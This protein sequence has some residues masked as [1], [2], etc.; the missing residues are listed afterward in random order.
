MW[1]WKHMHSWPNW[2]ILLTCP[3]F[4]TF[5][6]PYPSLYLHTLHKQPSN[7]EN[8]GGFSL[9]Q[10]RRFVAVLRECFCGDVFYFLQFWFSSQM[11][12]GKGCWAWPWLSIQRWVSMWDLT[13]STEC[14]SI[15]SKTF[16]RL[17]GAPRLH[18]N[19][20]VL[21]KPAYETLKS[22]LKYNS[23]LSETEVAFLVLSSPQHS[24]KVEWKG[25]R[26]RKICVFLAACD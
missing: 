2:K 13:S 21:S 10:K 19:S 22:N 7:T 3:G 4:F 5:S 24:S 25:L 8:T 6:F 17:V 26:K 20:A 23:V 11:C 14:S 9:A 12:R 1:S 18:Q 15:F 16:I